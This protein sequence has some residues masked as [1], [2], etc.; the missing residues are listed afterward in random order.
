MLSLYEMKSDSI[1][2][3]VQPDWRPPA[4]NG[5]DL[6]ERAGRANPVDAIGEGTASRRSCRG[7]PQSEPVDMAQ[8]VSEQ[9]AWN[10]V[11]R[12]GLAVEATCEWGVLD[13]GNIRAIRDR[14]NTKSAFP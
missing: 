2:D 14:F 11:S 6:V 8:N 3:D 7:R 10:V 5:A 12:P 4:D 9:L 1:W 13:N